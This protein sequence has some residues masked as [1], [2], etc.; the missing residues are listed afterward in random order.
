MYLLITF[1]RGKD[2]KKRKARVNT[3]AKTAVGSGVGGL[4]GTG[5]SAIANKN[6]KIGLAAG[7]LLGA[8]A[9]NIYSKEENKYNKSPLFYKAKVNTKETYEN[10]RNKT[11]KVI[12]KVNNVSNKLENYTNQ[13]LN[14]FGIFNVKQSVRTSKK[15]GTYVVRAHTRKRKDKV[16][17]LENTA[18][19]VA[20]V[21]GVSALGYV[22]LK[23]RYRANMQK[24]LANAVK[25]AET[26]DIS[27]F[28]INP[29]SE[30]LIFT[31]AGTGGIKNAKMQGDGLAG[32]VKG[33]TRNR[34]TFDITN[35]KFN[36]QSK[37]DYKA[38]TEEVT[39][40][41]NKWKKLNP[42]AT[43]EE[44]AEQA[45]KLRKLAGNKYMGIDHPIGIAKQLFKTYIKRGRNTQV[46]DTLATIIALHN[47]TGKPVNL[48]G[49]SG[50]GIVMDEVSEHLVNLKIPHK[51]VN[52][53]SP[54]FGFTKPSK[55]VI[56]V[57]GKKDPLTNILPTH[58]RKTVEGG[59]GHDIPDYLMDK[60]V[61]KLFKEH[62]YS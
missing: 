54:N 16:V 49:V 38:L 45:F 3:T 34:N 18:K 33:I 58:N 31:V 41:L 8:T 5:V 36:L 10:A 23:G 57:A 47:K 1:R 61:Q 43:T 42:S 62:L 28:K 24:T 56:G 53:G 25:K 50:G 30:S 39:N 29:K 46:E 48:V 44:I 21:I 11:K 6:K 55:N 59:R 13:D 35:K 19:V 12:K 37:F 52:L 7:M 26:L 2:L 32:A 9:G 14:T 40:N 60:E 27:K 15:K 17:T 4:L 51:G 20:G 22:A